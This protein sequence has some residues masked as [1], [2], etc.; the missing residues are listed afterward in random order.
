MNALTR[1]DEP[2]PCRATIP[3]AVVKQVFEN[4]N[5]KDDKGDVVKKPPAKQGKGWDDMGRNVAS[6]HDNSR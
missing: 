4:N 2:L 6:T 3:S 1:L 5:P